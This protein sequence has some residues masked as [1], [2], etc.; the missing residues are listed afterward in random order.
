MDHTGGY[1]PSQYRHEIGEVICARIEAGETV[2]S[3]ASDPDMPCYATIF[4]WTKVNPE[5]ADMYYGLRARL[6]QDRVR[7][8]RQKWVADGW[9]IPHEIRLGLRRHWVSGPKSTY[10]RAWAEQLCK[11][12]ADGES[13]LAITADRDM[14]SMKQVYGWLKR[15]EEFL[16]MYLAARQEQQIW[17]ELQI[18]MVAGEATPV[19]LDAAKAEVAWLEGRIGR[20]APRAYRAPPRR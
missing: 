19:T 18:D 4:R 17:L 7:A 15:H 6:A 13:L 1:K 3:I 9:R 14:P 5:F 2:A 8:R 16:D 11:R 20:L 12:L 10:D